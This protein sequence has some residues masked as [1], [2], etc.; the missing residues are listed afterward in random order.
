MVVLQSEAHCIPMHTPLQQ[1]IT[2]WHPP[3]ASPP[4]QSLPLLHVKPLLT[5]FNAHCS[6]THT[7]TSMLRDVLARTGANKTLKHFFQRV[8]R[9]DGAALL[10]RVLRLSCLLYSVQRNQSLFVGL[11]GCPQRRQTWTKA[12][13][14]TTAVAA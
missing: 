11:R 10:S 14:A 8:N 6:L 7:D 9:T 4:A 13:R 12:L 5:C 1:L 3:S 2:H